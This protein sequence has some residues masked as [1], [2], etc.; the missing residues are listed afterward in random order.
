MLVYQ[1]VIHE[2]GIPKYQHLSTNQYLPE[3]P[4]VLSTI[5]K[6]KNHGIQI[7]YLGKFHHD[8]T[9]TS[10]EIMVSIGNDPQMALIQ[11]SELL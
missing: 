10:L 3:R 6:G 11:V 4:C 1:R 9:A 2:M 5:A 7:I 8:L